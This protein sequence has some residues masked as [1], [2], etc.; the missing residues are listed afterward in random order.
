MT[1]EEQQLVDIIKEKFAEIKHVGIRNGAD[2]E[3]IAAVSEFSYI[4][5]EAIEVV[6]GPSIYISDFEGLFPQSTEEYQRLTSFGQ[7]LDPREEEPRTKAEFEEIKGEEATLT[8]PDDADKERA[9]PQCLEIPEKGIGVLINGTVYTNAE[10]LIEEIIKGKGA[11]IPSVGE[12]SDISELGALSVD[13]S[14]SLG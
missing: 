5:K 1:P 9:K 12:I 8:F 2:K 3:L 6:L 13:P 11:D 4:P 7:Y 14:H 10:C